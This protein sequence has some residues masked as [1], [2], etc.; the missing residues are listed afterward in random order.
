MEGTSEP[1]RDRCQCQI[2]ERIR[3][4]PCILWRSRASRSRCRWESRQSR[5][6]WWRWPGWRRWLSHDGTRIRR[7]WPS[8]DR[9]VYHAIEQA[10]WVNWTPWLRSQK[11]EQP[12]VLLY[13]QFRFQHQI[14]WSCQHRCHHHQCLRSSF[15]PCKTWEPCKLPLSKS[16]SICR[17]RHMEPALRH[18]RMHQMLPNSSRSCQE[19][20]RQ[21][22]LWCSS[23]PWSALKLLIQSLQVTWS[24]SWRKGSF[25][26]LWD[27]NLWQCLSQ[28]RL[29]RPSASKLRFQLT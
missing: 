25:Y 9:K 28:F 6:G 3:A 14:P 29:Y 4:V 12:K 18:W 7:G 26:E 19:S 8:D 22:S 17:C 24:P 2:R 11:Q 23:P 16:G 13:P 15:H 10:S 27:Q 20:F 5:K 1:S 21:W